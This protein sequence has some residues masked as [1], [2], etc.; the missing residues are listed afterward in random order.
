MPLESGE[1]QPAYQAFLVHVM[2]VQHFR[3]LEDAG[4]I[5]RIRKGVAKAMKDPAVI[6]KLRQKYIPQTP[7][8][9]AKIT[10][11][12]RMR[13][14]VQLHKTAFGS[15]L[16][17]CNVVATTGVSVFHCHIG[18]SAMVGFRRVGWRRSVVFRKRSSK[19]SVRRKLTKEEKQVCRHPMSRSTFAKIWAMP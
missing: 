1:G 5:E 10:A 16:K 14:G 8:A 7:E 18:C 13:Y 19:R 6:A 15:R 12:T 9:R 11:K 4:T 2:S 17:N 3:N